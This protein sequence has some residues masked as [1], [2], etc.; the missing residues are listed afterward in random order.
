MITIIMIDIVQVKYER[1]GLLQHPLIYRYINY[2]WWK[3]SFPVFMFYLLLYILFLI[4]LS[5]FAITVPRPGP[6]NEYC[7][8]MHNSPTFAT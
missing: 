4:F 2:K 8:F 1:L 3:M 5:S 6:N 7:E